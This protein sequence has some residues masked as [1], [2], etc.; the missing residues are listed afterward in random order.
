MKRPHRFHI[1]INGAFGNG[2]TY[3]T[4]DGAIEV[5]RGNERMCRAAPGLAR[6]CGFWR[7]CEFLDLWNWKPQYDPA[8]L[9]VAIRDGEEWTLHIAFDKSRVIRS[10]GFNAYPSLKSA[11]KSSLTHDRFG[12]LL[13]CIDGTILDQPVGNILSFASDNS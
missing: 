7:L 8:D 6:W 9:D 3:S 12:L 1:E 5:T 2:T 4:T 11:A 10:G 13:Q